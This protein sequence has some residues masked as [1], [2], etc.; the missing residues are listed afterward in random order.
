L[1]SL[2]AYVIIG[3]AISTIKHVVIAKMIATKRDALRLKGG[4][5]D[6]SDCVCPCAC[7]RARVVASITV[8][9]ST[10]AGVYFLTCAASFGAGVQ[11]FPA[12]KPRRDFCVLHRL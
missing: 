6:G 8:L 11:T 12:G 5:G 4:D 1:P 3:S 9:S 7:P 2:E 10:Q